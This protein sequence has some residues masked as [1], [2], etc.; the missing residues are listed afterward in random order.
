[1]HC[2]APLFVAGVEVL[3]WHGD[4]FELPDGAV[5][6]ASTAQYS[7]QA[8]AVGDFALALQFHP[9]VAVKQLERWYIGHAAELA[10]ARVSVAALREQ[11]RRHGPALEMAAPS[12]WHEWLQRALIE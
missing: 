5:H 3:H 6:L 2:L 10:Q 12:L 8:F 1:M 11:S 9:E 4:T 7:N